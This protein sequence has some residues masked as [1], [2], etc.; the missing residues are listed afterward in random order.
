[1]K[2]RPARYPVSLTEMDDATSGLADSHESIY[3]RILVTA[4]TVTS[5]KGIYTEW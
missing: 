2:K 3:Y 1:M 5:E 4:L